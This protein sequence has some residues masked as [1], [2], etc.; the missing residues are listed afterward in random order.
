MR[1]AALLLFFLLT[2]LTSAQDKFLVVEGKFTL[3]PPLPDPL[4]ILVSK[5]T[6]GGSDRVEV[7]KD[8][9]FTIKL[10]FQKEYKI[11]FSRKGYIPQFIVVN[12]NVDK[13]RIADA[14][15]P[16][17]FN[18]RLFEDIPGLNPA[19]IITNPIGKVFYQEDLNDFEWDDAYTAS[20]KEKLEALRAEV[21]IQKEKNKLNA[22]SAADL[23]K[24]RAAEAE[25]LKL[26]AAA[27]KKAEEE[28]QAAEKLRKAN[29]AAEAKARRD[30]EESARK[31][32]ELA[33]AREKREADEKTK[34]EADA[35]EKARKEKELAD[36]R[37]KREADEK[38][39]AEADAAEKSRKEKELADARAKREAD[40]KA[41]LEALENDRKAKEAAAAEE[42][43]LDELAKQEELF[44]AKR[45][46]FKPVMGVYSG[47][48]VKSIGD[49]KSYG[50]INFGNGIGNQDLTKEEYDAYAEKYLKKP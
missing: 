13:E 14:F 45:S 12:T 30:A 39:K 25:R 5:T 41:R 19:D 10:D 18:A 29:E 17:E 40:E 50:Y 43:R 9:N 22:L 28:A 32:K 42:A 1:W 47:A 23:E 6:G 26:E 20:M 46:A 7:D 11:L 44:K 16:K 36:A 24:Q 37:A 15:Y 21:K 3:D 4:V 34:A 35:A 49:K 38:A 8:G 2:N 33:D 31:E 27:R 48:S